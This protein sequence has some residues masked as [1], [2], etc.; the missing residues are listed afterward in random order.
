M[1]YK[2]EDAEYDEEDCPASRY[3]DP[4]LN[5][6]KVWRQHSGWGCDLHWIGVNSII[7]FKDTRETNRY[8]T[9]SMLDSISANKPVQWYTMGKSHTAQSPASCTEEFRSNLTWDEV[10]KTTITE[11]KAEKLEPKE[12]KPTDISDW[13]TWARVGEGMCACGIN[14]KDC[15]YHR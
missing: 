7:D 9:Q 8:V 1:I 11:R 4:S 12:T 5:C 15:D 6:G 10:F 13:R 2:D 3:D 14:K